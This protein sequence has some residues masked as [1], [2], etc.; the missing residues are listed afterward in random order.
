MNFHILNKEEWDRKEYFEHYLNLKC[1]FN[2]TSNID[3]TILLEHLQNKG[4]KIYPAFIYMVIRTVNAHKEFRTCF[5]DEDVLGYWDNMVPSYTIFH[6]DDKS[7]SSIWSDFSDDFDVFYQN[8]QDDINQYSDVKGLFPKEN[9]P[10]NSF[11]ISSV[12]WISFTGFNLNINNDDNYLLPIITGGKY[13]NQGDKVL[14]PVSV[15]MHHAV[16]DGYHASL[17]FSEL[18]QFA[19]TCHEWLHMD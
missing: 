6:P 13:F 11:P 14:L 2:L 4:L 19:D 9:E 5:K 3:I 12:P 17:F 8:Y 1:T 10:R 18:Q 16:C 7:F 15:Q